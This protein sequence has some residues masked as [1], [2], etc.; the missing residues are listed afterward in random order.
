MR[1]AK[2]IVFRYDG[3]PATEEIDLDMDGDKSVPKQG[4]FRASEE[5]PGHEEGLRRCAPRASAGSGSP[6]TWE[7]SRNY[8]SRCPRGFQ[9]SGK[10]FL[11]LSCCSSDRPQW[12]ES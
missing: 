7:S 10:G 8:L 5:A 2:Q 3:D 4:S 11:N 9:N 12:R 6:L 1:A